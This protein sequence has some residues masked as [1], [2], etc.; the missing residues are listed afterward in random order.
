[1]QPSA[2]PPKNDPVQYPASLVKAPWKAADIPNN[3]AIKEKAEAISETLK[4]LKR[5]YIILDYTPTPEAPREGEKD[6][7]ITFI[8]TYNT[9]TVDTYQQLGLL[10]TLIEETNDIL[11]KYKGPSQPF[12]KHL[13]DLNHETV[14]FRGEIA[15]YVVWMVKTYNDL[16]GT[17]L[18]FKNGEPI[19]IPGSLRGASPAKERPDAH[20]PRRSTASGNLMLRPEYPETLSLEAWKSECLMLNNGGEVQKTGI[21]NKIREMR[22]HFKWPKQN[23]IFDNSDVCIEQFIHEYGPTI[24]TALTL[25]LQLRDLLNHADSYVDLTDSTRSRI[26]AYRDENNRW[27][28]EVVKYLKWLIETYNKQLYPNYLEFEKVSFNISRKARH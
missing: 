3:Q 14:K 9:D 6:P 17:E 26:A 20:S 12:Q 24:R 28:G 5:D 2:H 1:M 13:A 27:R 11:K 18:K 16:R 19:S 8:H 15:H 10:I 23:I 25:S 21:S 22:H 4:I 7:F